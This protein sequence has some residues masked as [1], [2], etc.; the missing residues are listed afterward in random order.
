[1]PAAQVGI[2]H[3]GN[4]SRKNT[5]DPWWHPAPLAEVEALADDAELYFASPRTP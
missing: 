4:T 1:L 2:V 5:P 3:D